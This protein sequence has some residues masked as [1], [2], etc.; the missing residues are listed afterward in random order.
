MPYIIPF[1]LQDIVLG[2]LVR[3]LTAPEQEPS[4]AF[5]AL[6]CCS[7]VCKDWTAICQNAYMEHVNLDLSGPSTTSFHTTWLGS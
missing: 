1:E 5:R 4:L 3:E 7:F 6:T 2:H